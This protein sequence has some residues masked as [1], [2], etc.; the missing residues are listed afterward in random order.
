[1]NETTKPTVV[2]K[3]TKAK[4]VEEQNPTIQ[5]LEN[6]DH[7]PSVRNEAVLLMQQS[8]KNEVM[9]GASCAS[10]RVHEGSPIID[11]ETKQQKV[12]INTQ[13]P[14][15]YANKYYTTLTFDG[16]EIET[17]V[18]KEQYENVLQ[19]GGRF[20]CVGRLSPVKVFGQ[21]QIMPVFYSFTR[22]Y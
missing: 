17:E 8:N 9:L 4:T 2:K 21:T 10:K 6:H 7:Q 1:M 22:L 12:D 18:T 14:L 20:S 11:K 19:E 16:G 3:T 5:S 13:Q 15:F